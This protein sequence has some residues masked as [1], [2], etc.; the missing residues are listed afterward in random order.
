M[1]GWIGLTTVEKGTTVHGNFSSSL[2]EM[3][4]TWSDQTVKRL[5]AFFIAIVFLF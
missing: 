2:I 1:D 5:R 3:I 4:T